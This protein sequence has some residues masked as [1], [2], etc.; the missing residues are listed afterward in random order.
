MQD[1]IQNTI[2]GGLLT[3]FI[4]GSI[5]FYFKMTTEIIKIKENQQ[6]INL[7]LL[8][9]TIYNKELSLEERIRAGEEYKELGGNGI[10]KIYIERLV[11]EYNKPKEEK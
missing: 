4:A 7:K 9:L 2:S 10:T 1:I 5:T 11:A 8:R 3:I 6:Q